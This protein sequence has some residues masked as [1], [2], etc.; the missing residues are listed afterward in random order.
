MT[1]DNIDR[2]QHD[3]DHAAPGPHELFESLPA[4]SAPL[5]QE[6][7][8]AAPPAQSTERTRDPY[9]AAML[10]LAVAIF[11]YVLAGGAG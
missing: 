2:S 9:H 6:N 4:A 8:P 5:E 3:S 1:D 7:T 10:A 11:V